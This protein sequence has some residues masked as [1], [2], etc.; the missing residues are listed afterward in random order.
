MM[1][2]MGSRRA[3]VARQF[4]K[5]SWRSLL[6]TSARRSPESSTGVPEIKVDLSSELGTKKCQHLAS[7]P[8]MWFLVVSLP[9]RVDMD[10]VSATADM[11][12]RHHH[13]G[14]PFT[15]EASLQSPLWNSQACKELSSR[16]EVHL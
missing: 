16:S 7:L 15:A 8:A 12:R 1:L 5:R 11:V 10:Y 4:Q 14:R 6:I 9:S 3:P 13:R 2:E